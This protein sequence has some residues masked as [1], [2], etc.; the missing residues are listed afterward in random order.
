MAYAA[1]SHP[2]S[3]NPLPPA[4]RVQPGVYQGGP[5]AAASAGQPR[6]VQCLPGPGAPVV[7][8]GGSGSQLQ[9]SQGGAILR[10]GK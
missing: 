10:R 9:G 4:H 5:Q 7:G 1:L 6:Q 3:S 8:T 2:L